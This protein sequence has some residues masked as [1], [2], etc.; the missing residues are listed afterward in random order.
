MC[1]KDA[2]QGLQIT[3]LAPKA[4]VGKQLT[5]QH[6]RAQILADFVPNS[7]SA[8]HLRITGLIFLLCVALLSA[9]RA[10]FDRA[11]R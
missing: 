6:S 1:Q 4:R 3:T 7:V 5:A 11:L 9:I 2:A 8:V 10:I